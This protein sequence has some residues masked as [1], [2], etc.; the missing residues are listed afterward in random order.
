MA[1]EHDVFISYA[2]IDNEPSLEGGEGWVS[3]FHHALEKRLTKLLGKR[4]K[5][6]R[7]PKLHGNDYFSNEIEEQFPKVA[8]L[9]SVLTPS[10]VKSDWCL[11]ELHDFCLAASQTGGVKVVGNQSRIFKAIKTPLPLEQHP[12]ELQPLLGYEFFEVNAAN[13]PVEYGREFGPEMELKFVQTI[14]EL[15]YDIYKL[16]QE[17]KSEGLSSEPVSSKTSGQLKPVPPPSGKV[18]YLAETC[19]TL[20]AVRDQMRRDLALSGHL[21]LPDRPLPY[22]SEFSSEIRAMLAKCDLSVHLLASESSPADLTESFEAQLPQ[23]E[24]ARMRTQLK[25]AAKKVAERTG[26]T[27][28]VWMPGAHELEVWA[29]EVAQLPGYA[30]VLQTPVEELKTLVHMRIEHPVSVSVS[31]RKRGERA[32]VYLDFDRWD[33]DDAEL[34]RVYDLLSQQF[35]VLMPDYEAGEGLESSEQKLQRAQGVLIFY[36]QGS[37]FWLKRRLN[38]LRKCFLGERSQLTQGVFLASPMTPNKLELAVPGVLA[39]CEQVPFLPPL[40]SFIDHVNQ[41]SEV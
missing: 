38:A 30:D 7:D 21:V 15:A 16:L 40:Q 4:P 31:G 39:F 3:S 33:C 19:C 22:S 26:F 23:I 34:E 24:T 29:S 27:Q 14:N 36:G 35:K 13:V 41:S 10:Y 11:K 8:L 2:H 37:E 20:S 6:W 9:I 25:L 1:F 5:I 12:N 17:F 28:V 32:V 18:V